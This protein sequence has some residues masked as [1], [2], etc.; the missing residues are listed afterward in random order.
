VEVE[1]ISLLHPEVDAYAEK[2]PHKLVFKEQD[3]WKPLPFEFDFI[4]VMGLMMTDTFS[5]QP[6]T[7]VPYFTDKKVKEGLMNLGNAL[8]KKSES[9]SE[10]GLL[11]GVASLNREYYDFYILKGRNQDVL[12]AQPTTRPFVSNIDEIGRSISLTPPNIFTHKVATFWPPQ[13]IAASL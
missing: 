13:A 2:N 10:S 9:E 4:R 7:A 6:G 8:K 1:T 5:S 12:E 3:A 11:V